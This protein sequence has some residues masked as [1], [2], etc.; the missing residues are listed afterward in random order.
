MTTQELI[1]FV[2]ESWDI[3]GLRLI[4]DR[5][6]IIEAHALFLEL[7]H[8]KLVDLT[9]TTK[10]FATPKGDL[11]L[12]PGCD[13]RVGYHVS[14]PGGP[15]IGYMLDDLVHRVN[16]NFADLTVG[17]L[18]PF[19]VY[20]EFETIHPFTDG[21]GRMGRLL[22]AWCME[23][24]GNDSRWWARGFLKTYHYQALDAG[25]RG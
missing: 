1:A 22:W 5:K 8:L 9:T 16:D 6:A 14:P 19:D 12:R 10:L 20:G 11:R 7:G 23:G 24:L 21:N 17:D 4:E 15:G 18:N 3:E 2:D 13:V 25:R